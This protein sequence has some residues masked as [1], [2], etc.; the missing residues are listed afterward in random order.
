MTTKMK[1]T[2]KHIYDNIGFG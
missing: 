1:R 2:F